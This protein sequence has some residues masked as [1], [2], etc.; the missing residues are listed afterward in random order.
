MPERPLIVLPAPARANRGYW[1]PRG[2]DPHLPSRARQGA[3]LAP[4]LQA[5]QNYFQQQTVLHATAAGQIPEEVIVFE[6][7]GSAGNFLEAA[8]LIPGFDFLADWTSEEIAPDA[9]FYD[10]K[11]R[12][13]ALL[14][15]LFL[16]MSDQRALQ[17]LLRLWQRFQSSRR[18]DTGF[19]AYTAL[20]RH[21]HDVRL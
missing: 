1:G 21:L 10:T 4:R 6:T 12:T 19:A 17:Q 13:K 15:R 3:R 20:F 14:H 16:V 5:V 7:I 11:D 2:R 8:K 9:D 18:M